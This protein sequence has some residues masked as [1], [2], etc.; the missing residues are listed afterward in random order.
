MIDVAGNS[1][2]SSLLPMMTDLHLRIAPQSAYADEETV[3]MAPLPSTVA[4]FLTGDE[5]ILAKLDVQGF[6][7]GVLR[8]AREI[9]P[10]VRVIE[11]EMST[12]PL[13]EGQPL[14]DEVVLFVAERGFHL[15]I[16]HG[17]IIDADTGHLLQLDGVFA[18]SDSD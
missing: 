10:I 4:T 11:V 1:V 3:P 8:G 18:R 2:S 17:L 7:L 6:E 14:W 9:L 12:R 13:Y 16:A 5:R 15:S